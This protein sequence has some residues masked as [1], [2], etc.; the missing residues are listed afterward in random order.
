MTKNL[1]HMISSIE[2]DTMKLFTTNFLKQLGNQL[3]KNV[4]IFDTDTYLNPKNKKKPYKSRLLNKKQ[5]PLLR[6]GFVS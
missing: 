4:Y 5:A 1:A 6:Y 3:N 2:F